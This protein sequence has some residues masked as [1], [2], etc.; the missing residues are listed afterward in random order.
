MVPLFNSIPLRSCAFEN[1]FF[2]IVATAEG[3]SF[4]TCNA[5]RDGYGFKGITSGECAGFDGCYTVFDFVFIY[6]IQ[7]DKRA[8]FA[9]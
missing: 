4:Y 8:V 9:S 2:Q 1:D 3:V 5:G 7:G 6:V